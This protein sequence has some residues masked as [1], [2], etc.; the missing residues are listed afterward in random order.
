[1]T[2]ENVPGTIEVPIAAVGTCP[3]GKYLFASKFL[4]YSAADTAGFARILLRCFHDVSR[5]KHKRLVL[6]IG[7]KP[8]VAPREHVF[9]RL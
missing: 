4:V 5:R 3:A 7:S 1:M 9:R 6:K 8:E 2:N